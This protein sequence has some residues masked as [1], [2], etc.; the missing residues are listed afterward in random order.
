MKT[1]DIGKEQT[2]SNGTVH[3]CSGEVLDTV[4]R[5]RISSTLIK[6]LSSITLVESKLKDRLGGG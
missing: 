1:G 3:L 6:D 2:K 4:L 5:I